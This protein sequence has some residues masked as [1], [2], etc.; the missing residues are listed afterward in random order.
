MAGTCPENCSFEPEECM[1]H[2]CHKSI[3]IIDD[4]KA[5]NIL[6]EK[7]VDELEEIVGIQ[8]TLINELYKKGGR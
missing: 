5:E 2:D 4:V 3:K 8:M 7:L 1:I 6:L